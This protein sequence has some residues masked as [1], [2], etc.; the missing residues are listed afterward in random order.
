M[1][2][3]DYSPEKIRGFYRGADRLSLLR[4]FECTPC[5]NDPKAQDRRLARAVNDAAFWRAA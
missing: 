1:I 3:F 4:S 2:S 5:V